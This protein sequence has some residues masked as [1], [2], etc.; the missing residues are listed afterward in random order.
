MNEARDLGFIM[1]Q[2]T[3]ANWYLDR[4][5]R[6]DAPAAQGYLAAAGQAQEL[7]LRMLAEMP[8]MIARRDEVRRGLASVQERLMLAQEISRSSIPDPDRFE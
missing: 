5:L 8:D 4:A 7:L 6:A 3:I 1:A 2:L